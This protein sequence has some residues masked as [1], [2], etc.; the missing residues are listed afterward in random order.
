MGL[1]GNSLLVDLDR[2]LEQV[3]MVES[4]RSVVVEAIGEIT[5]LRERLAVEIFSVPK[6]KRK[7]KQEAV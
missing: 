4:Q 6:G 3:P 2:L 5:Q 7:R 1:G